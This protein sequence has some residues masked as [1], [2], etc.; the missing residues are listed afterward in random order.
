M[1]VYLHMY[2]YCTVVKY[3]KY[4]CKYVPD[5]SAEPKVWQVDYLHGIGFFCEGMT[6]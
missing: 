6:L 1:K 3:G 2:A 4:L 5:V